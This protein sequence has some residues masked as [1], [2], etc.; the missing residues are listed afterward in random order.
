MERKETVE[1]ISSKINEGQLKQQIYRDLLP[2]IRYKT[3]LLAYISEF[4]DLKS[5]NQN[6]NEQI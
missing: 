4:P 2:K 1:Y 5:R 3:D 6:K